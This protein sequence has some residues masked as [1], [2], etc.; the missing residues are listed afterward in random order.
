MLILPKPAQ[1]QIAFEAR[2][3]FP[4]ECCGLLEG[5]RLEGNIVVDTVHP[6]R[7]VAQENDRFEI[8]PAEQFALIRA[9]RERK[10]EILGCYHS[11]PNGR[12]GPSPRDAQNG[13]DD[14]F[15]WLIAAL[16]KK[17]GPVVVNA[18]V[19]A[20]GAFEPLAVAIGR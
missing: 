6:T 8:D 12:E 1:M 4:R 13:S 16:T 14:G 17:S 7:N 5:A 10:H 18:Y 15:V 2:A 20:S 3:I 9:A 19:F 11:H